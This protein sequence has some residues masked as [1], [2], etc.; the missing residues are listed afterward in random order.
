MTRTEQAALDELH[1]TPEQLADRTAKMEALGK[2]SHAPVTA[3]TEP[4]TSAWC[5]SHASANSTSERTR[6]QRADAGQPRPF[7]LTIPG[8]TFHMDTQQGID[9]FRYW[10]DAAIERKDVLVPLACEQLVAE[11]ERLRAK[12]GGQ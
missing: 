7:R 3:I 10:L 9:A 5:P 1:M 11:I 2:E 6:K 4:T 8:V 12:N